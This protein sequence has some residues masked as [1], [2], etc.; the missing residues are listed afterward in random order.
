MKKSRAN[1]PVKTRCKMGETAIPRTD[2]CGSPVPAPCESQCTASAD[3]AVMLP[4]TMV[5]K[6]FI[7]QLFLYANVSVENSAR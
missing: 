5:P 7:S 2:A 4:K 3:N 6:C 1:G